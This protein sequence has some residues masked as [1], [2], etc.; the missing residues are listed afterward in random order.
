[1]CRIWSKSMKRWRPWI[2]H[3]NTHTLRIYTDRYQDR[4]Q[5]NLVFKLNPIPWKP[6]K[7]YDFMHK[8]IKQK[9]GIHLSNSIKS[10]FSIVIG[11]L[12]MFSVGL[13]LKPCLLPMNYLIKIKIKIMIKNWNGTATGT[14]RTDTAT[15]TLSIGTATETVHKK[16]R[17]IKT[18]H[19]RRT[20]K[21]RPSQP[22]RQR[23]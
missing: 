22:K 3:T 17:F 16:R 12:W 13:S 10:F 18:K 19:D 21:T 20:N 4:N 5:N 1:M 15:E 11:E 23:E 2:S 6:Q 8:I 9:K 14:I 7:E